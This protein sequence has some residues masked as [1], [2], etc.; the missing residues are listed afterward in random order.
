MDNLVTLYYGG[1]IKKD[2][3]GNITFDGMHRI[4]LIFDDQL[5]FSELFDR[6]RDKLQCNSNEDAISIQ[7]VGFSDG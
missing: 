4:S 2:V 5:L 1:S 3:F 6:A 7:R